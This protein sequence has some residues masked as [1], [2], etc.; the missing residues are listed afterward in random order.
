M[1]DVDYN[2][3]PAALVQIVTDTDVR[4]DYSSVLTRQDHFV[5]TFVQRNTNLCSQTDIL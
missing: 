4:I 5:V 2:D 3:S 1:A